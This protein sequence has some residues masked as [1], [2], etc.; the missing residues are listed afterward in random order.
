[1][2]TSPWSE[3]EAS[4]CTHLVFQTHIH[5]QELPACKGE[6]LCANFVHITHPAHV[7]MRQV[8]EFALKANNDTLVTSQFALSSKFLPI[9]TI[10]IFRIQCHVLVSVYSIYTIYTQY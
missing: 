6:C 8:N 10:L 9:K 5:G 7:I 4:H 3:L 2:F 1:M